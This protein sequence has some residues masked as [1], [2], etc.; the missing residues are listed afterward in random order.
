MNEY[1]TRESRNPANF[2]ELLRREYK[3]LE[4]QRN[5]QHETQD[6]EYSD[7]KNELQNKFDELFGDED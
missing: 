4:E 6:G 7:L 5:N 1:K 2:R 3:D